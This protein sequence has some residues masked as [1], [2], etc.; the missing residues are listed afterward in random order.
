MNKLLKIKELVLINILNIIQYKCHP[1]II[2]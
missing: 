1:Q 2:C